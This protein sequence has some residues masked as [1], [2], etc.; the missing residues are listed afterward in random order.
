MDKICPYCQGQHLIKNGSAYGVP[1][2]RAAPAKW[3]CKDCLRQTSFKP[4]RGEPLWKKETVVL[5]YTLSMNAIA[6]QLGVSTPSILNWIRAHAATHAPRP[7]PDPGE[8]V[9][10]MELDELW[11]FLQKKNKLWIWLAFDRSGQRLVD[12]ECGNRDAATLNRLLERLKPWSCTVQTTMR[13]TTRS[14]RLGGTISARMKRWRLSGST[15]GCVIGLPAFGLCGV[16]SA[17]DGRRNHRTVCR[18]PRQWNRGKT[19]F[20]TACLTPSE[21]RLVGSGIDQAVRRD[22]LQLTMDHRRGALI[23]GREADFRGHANL[24]AV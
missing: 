3:R 14:C 12:W 7:Q 6:K 17:R 23:E 11:H 21:I 8:S 13:L 9:V 4:P 15:A 24:K 18:L 20:A 10:V 19:H 16:E 5:L 1:T 2:R 22:C